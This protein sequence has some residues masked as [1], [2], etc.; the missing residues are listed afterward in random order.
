MQPRPLLAMIAVNELT[1]PSPTALVQAFKALSGISV[2][3]ASLQSKQGNVVFEIG[4][5]HAAIGLMPIPIPW[6]NLEGP[7]L[8]AWWWPEAAEKMKSHKGHVLVAL[9]GDQGDAIR[10]AITLTQLTAAV[11]ASVDAAGI[12]WGGGAL[13]H[14][15]NAFVKEAESVSTA[16]L[17]LQLWIDFR[18]GQN[19]DDSL[20]LFT[21]GMALF[22]QKEIE[23]PRT[24]KKPND[25]LDFAYAIADYVL[26]SGKTIQAGETVG[27]SEDEKVPV[28]YGPSMWDPETS[29][30]ILDF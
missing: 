21:T 10:R 19:E 30:M 13:V 3:L 23:M 8:T 24:T 28:T 14:D 20:R 5:D 11:A 1:L 12:Y 4:N 9:V 25:V 15:P 7:C 18:L 6:S 26:T 27:R 16:S 22:D 2:D 29:V 17:P